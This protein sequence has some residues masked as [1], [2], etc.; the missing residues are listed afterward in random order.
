MAFGGSFLTV[1]GVIVLVPFFINI[2]VNT[3]NSHSTY[4]P[5]LMCA[6]HRAAT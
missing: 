4:H 5:S 6:M 1:F 3:R 2:A